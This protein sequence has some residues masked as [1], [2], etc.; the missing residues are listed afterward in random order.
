MSFFGLDLEFEVIILASIGLFI[1]FISFL[2]A[3][4][5]HR[6]FKRSKKLEITPRLNETRI[7]EVSVIQVQNR[8][9]G[10]N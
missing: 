1:I 7:Q 4:C 10:S 5:V 2:F 9:Q 8:S 3:F 6:K